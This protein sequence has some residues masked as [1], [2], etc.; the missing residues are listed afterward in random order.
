[1]A[2]TVADLNLEQLGRTDAPGGSTV[3]KAS[4]TGFDFSDVGQV[5]HNVGA[6]FGFHIDNDPG[7]DAFF[8]RS[9]NQALADLGVPSH[10]I[11]AAYEFPD[12]HKVGDEWQKIDYDNMAKLD[13]VITAAV[14][15]IANSS[16][17]PQWNVDSK[18][19]EK[20]RKAAQGLHP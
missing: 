18:S 14:L 11:A 17:T 13:R 15:E 16:K 19:A 9:D 1:M 3:G 4:V 7:N 10:T 8:A 12:Y 5:L 20:Y 2:R 6:E